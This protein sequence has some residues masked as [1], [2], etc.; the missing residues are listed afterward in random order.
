M[1]KKLTIGIGNVSLSNLAKK[2]VNEVIDSNRL[3][4]GKFSRQFEEKMAKIHSRDFAIFCNSGTSA[5]QV[6]LQ[7]LKDKYKWSDGDEVLVPSVTFIATSNV[8]I[9]NNL[10]PV[11]VDVE[12]DFFCIDPKLIESKIT[13]KTRAIIPV[14]L[15]GQSSD[16]ANIMSIAR[17]HNL[18]VV[19]DS[20]EAMFVNYKG[21]PVG[22]RGDIACFSTYATHLITTGV[23]GLAMTNDA[24]LAVRIKSYFNHGRDGIY[25]SI[26]DDDTTESKKLFKIVERR[27]SFIHL[28]HSMRLTELEAAVG[29]AATVGYKNVVSKR[30]KNSKYIIKRLKRWEKFLRLPTIR[31]GAEHAFMLFPIVVINEKISRDKLIEYLEINGVETRYLMPLLTQPIYKELFGNLINKYPQARKL[32]KSGFIIGCH[33]DINSKE[34]EYLG[35]LFDTFFESNF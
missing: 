13:K 30:Q 22:S 19:E 29:L 2:Y 20:C 16:M 35:D 27:F 6:A 5:L 9:H 11:F 21:K 14:H 15:F 33:Q 8:V 7:V 24:D 1:S 26:D 3:S 23:G 25:L 17:K 4:Y 31:P 32:D 18:K 28:G 10:K 34:L 12:E